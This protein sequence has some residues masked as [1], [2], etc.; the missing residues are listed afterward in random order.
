VPT[1]AVSVW[2]SWV[3]PEI[4]G[5]EESLGFGVGGVGV[6]VVVGGV[7]VVVGGVVVVVGGVVVA[8]VVVVVVV[9]VAGVTGPTTFEF[10]V[11]P[12]DSVSTT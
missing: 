12:S 10:T 1:S 11:V 9:V 5:A 4:D 6:V 7:V 3:V 8:V 2:P